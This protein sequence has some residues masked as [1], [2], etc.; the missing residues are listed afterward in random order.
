MSDAC[1][2]TS[3]S[4]GVSHSRLRFPAAAAQPSI[5]HQIIGRSV[6][7]LYLYRNYPALI[8]DSWSDVSRAETTRDAYKL[9]MLK[10]STACGYDFIILLLKGLTLHT[11]KIHHCTV[12]SVSFHITTVVLGL[13]YRSDTLWP[14][15]GTYKNVQ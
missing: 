13:Q 2:V 3:E 7:V 8:D 10:T 12:P 14:L 11:H 1:K 4:S 9:L 15:Q 6:H 5:T